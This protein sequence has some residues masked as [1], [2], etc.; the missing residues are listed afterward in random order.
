V[1]R[2]LQR[3]CDGKKVEREKEPGA[4]SKKALLDLVKRELETGVVFC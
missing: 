4:I 1:K 3:D 2:W